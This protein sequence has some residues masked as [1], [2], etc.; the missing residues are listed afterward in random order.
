VQATPLPGKFTPA[1][2]VSPTPPCSQ[3]PIRG[4]GKV[5]SDQAWARD[6]VGCASYSIEKGMKFQAQR[7]ERGVMIW[8]DADIWVNRN[9]VW[10]LFSDDQTYARIPD[11]YDPGMAEPTPLTPPKGKLEP[12]G[13][14]GKA[15]REGGGVKDRLGWAIE[16]PTSGG[17]AYQEFDRGLMYWIPFK[18]D[19]RWIYVLTQYWP[20]PP[21]GPR[22]DWAAYLDTWQ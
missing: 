1:P 19:D 9:V 16:P 11:T 13:R 14:L 8:S 3:L 2:G 5:W 6:L 15:W 7:F 18:A 12:R 17:G 22:I 4:F 21:C 10:V 20:C